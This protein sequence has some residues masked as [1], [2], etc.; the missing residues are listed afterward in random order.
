MPK[1]WK[2]SG[3]QDRTKPPDLSLKPLAA[4]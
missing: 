3:S 1:G 4:E 2:W